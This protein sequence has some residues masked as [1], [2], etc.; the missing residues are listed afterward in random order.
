[1]K[2]LK[3]YGSTHSEVASSCILIAE[4]NYALEE[5]E[6]AIVYLRKA[7]EFA[8]PNG[9]VKHPKIAATSLKFL[10]IF[11]NQMG[12]PEE[13]IEHFQE[14]IQIEAT[15]YGETSSLLVPS[16]NNL[17]MIYQSL[18]QVH[19][20]LGCFMKAL[21]IN[22]LN[23]GEK[24]HSVL[25]SY[26]EIVTFLFTDLKAYESSI[27][28]I[29]K[30]I[31]L[32]TF[33]DGEIH[34]MN[35]SRFLMLGECY[36]N[37]SEYQKAIDAYLKC[38]DITKAMDGERSNLYEELFY[39]IGLLY[40]EKDE[41]QNALNALFKSLK[42]HLSLHEN[43]VS[44]AAR[45]YDRIADIFMKL[46]DYKTANKYYLKARTVYRFL[47]REDRR[48]SQLARLMTLKMDPSLPFLDSIQK[49]R[50]DVI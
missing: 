1:V 21:D 15:I 25:T 43:P 10:G 31:E 9:H 3:L 24:S 20:A 16:W 41:N 17:G 22:K 42:L 35:K 46:K 29:L 12:H 18:D 49:D 40:I 45:L 6:E 38:A 32:Q 28:F 26:N 7:L 8:K 36:K 33:F 27:E 50:D 47:A 44:Q 37:L 2:G 19:H 23:D 13:G 5:R 34:E 14:G 39:L 11:L 48:L 4:I 30:A